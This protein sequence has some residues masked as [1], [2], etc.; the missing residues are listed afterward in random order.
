MNYSQSDMEGYPASRFSLFE[1]ETYR[2]MEN[3]TLPGRVYQ[4]IGWNF[5]HLLS[6][7]KKTADSIRD[8]K[9]I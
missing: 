7:D 8:V 9:C 2:L 1:M 3:Q 4:D 6:R 5:A